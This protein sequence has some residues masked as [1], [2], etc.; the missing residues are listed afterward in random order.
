[1]PSG[2]TSGRISSKSSSNRYPPGL[3]PLLASY[4]VEDLSGL[5]EKRDACRRDGQQA[6]EQ[7][8]FG[9][10]KALQEANVRLQEAA[11]QKERFDRL[12]SAKERQAQLRLKA[13]EMDG[14]RKQY[15]Y[16]VKLKGV[17][18]YFQMWQ[19]AVKRER[20]A[21]GEEQESRRRESAAAVACREAQEAANAIPR[22]QDEAEEE[23]RRA[24]RPDGRWRMQSV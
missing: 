2:Q 17:Q 12:S 18:P 11:R 13:E 24:Q 10:Q 3:A 4:Q 19:S 5:L 21:K 8:G 6:K 7:E 20:D 23:S 22:L 9:L 16:G 14:F 1:M 15:A